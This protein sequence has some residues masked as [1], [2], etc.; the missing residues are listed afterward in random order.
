MILSGLRNYSSALSAALS[1]ENIPESVYHNLIHAVHEALPAMHRYVAA[2]KKALKL[3]SLHMY[4][5]YTPLVSLPEKHYTFEEAV[6]IAC[7]ALKPLGE[8]YVSTCE[9]EFWKS[10]GWTLWRTRERLPVL[11]ASEYMTAIRTSL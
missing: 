2:R 4:D 3:D 5:V 6:D 9:P 7:E 8:D 11:T 10:A 1:P